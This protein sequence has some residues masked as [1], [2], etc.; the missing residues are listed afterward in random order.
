[1]ST[2]NSVYHKLVVPV[3]LSIPVILLYNGI[4]SLLPGRIVPSTWLLV[5]GFLL[6]ATSYLLPAT[7]YAAPGSPPNP[8]PCKNAIEADKLTDNWITDGNGNPPIVRTLT[9]P[10][11]IG[12]QVTV[13]LDTSFT[14]DFS[15]LQAIF[16]TPNSNY[17]EGRFQDQSHQTI[18][19]TSLKSSDFNKY[20]G[21]GQK[22]APKAMT[23]QL[24]VKYVDYVYNKPELAESVN[25]YADTKGVDPK[26][27]YD[28]VNQFGLPNPPDPSDDRTT[29]L[30]T[31]GRYWEKIPTAY[32]EF[33]TGELQFRLA[34]GQETFTKIK[35]G[36]IC[37]PPIRTIKFVMPDFFRTTATSG[38]LN[39][40]VVPKAAQSQENN[41][42]ILKAAVSTKNTLAKVLEKCFQAATQNPIS[43]SLRKVIKV[44]L[45]HIPRPIENAYAAADQPS[46][47]PCIRVLDKSKEGTAPY[48]A[49]PAGELQPGDSCTN[50]NPTDPN[51]LDRNNPNVVCTFRLF[52]QTTLTFGDKSSGGDFDSCTDTNGDGVIDTCT[53]EV[54]VWPVFRIPWLAEIW[55]NSLYSDSD[56]PG[57]VSGQKT[58]RPGVYTFF[59]PQSV[60]DQLLPPN[61]QK[62]KERCQA[63]NQSACQAIL[64]EIGACFG[65]NIF[66]FYSCIA[67]L[68][69]RNLPGEV[70]QTDTK[71]RFVGATDCSKGFTRDVALKPKALQNALG[72]K[73]GCQTTP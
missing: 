24:R 65:L 20:H 49:L 45:E 18:D 3:V 31:W 44:T 23:D 46:S 19:L 40:V 57:I 52:W 25:T 17:L 71:E 11:S 7:S 35:N 72:I 58:G 8:Q 47:S 26:T 59:T 67:K 28:L 56:E 12:T 6:L 70:Q 32:S 30:A 29:W 36:E 53:I 14:V 73:T 39:Q 13:T 37:P 16:G 62:L 69:T 22:A 55:N 9:A 61:L 64:G 10:G 34:S 2:T 41:N 1:L 33:Y 27:V 43:K 50:P 15:K 5:A 51:K 54:R 4:M 63:G 42:L 66:E 60:S 21:P 38:Q 68:V 48:C